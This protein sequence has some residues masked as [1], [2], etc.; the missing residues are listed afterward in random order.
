VRAARTLVR[1]ALV[2]TLCVALAGCNG[3]SDEKMPEVVGKPE[4][5]AKKALEDLGLTV[6]TTKKR[7]GAAAGTVVDQSPHAG[8]AIPDDGKVTLIVE[9][10]PATG[11][12]GV[13]DVVGKPSHQAEEQLAQAGFRRGQLT[14]RVSGQPKDTVI[15]QNPRAGANAAAGTLVDLVLADDSMVLVPNLVGQDELTALKVLTEQQLRV[16][17]VRRVLEGAGNPGAILEHNPRAAVEVPRDTAVDLLIKED[18]VRVPAVVGKI[19]NDVA[20]MLLT[21]GLTYKLQYQTDPKRP[22]G[23]IASSAPAPNELVARNSEV[24]LIV[25]RPRPWV[26]ERETAITMEKLEGQLAK[27]QH[28]RIIKPNQ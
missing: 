12:A 11:T 14:R 1:T 17:N 19:I 20:P 26:F 15:E 22:R 9:D 7:T 28:F 23:T 2:A 6:D 25:T 18:G 13:P 10:A 8:D 3:G 5:E 4:A 24:T 21:S 16:G 27:P